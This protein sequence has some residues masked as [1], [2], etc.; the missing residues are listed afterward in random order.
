M[1]SWACSAAAGAVGCAN[2]T[3]I[4]ERAREAGSAGRN[5]G[6]G[7]AVRPAALGAAAA[8]SLRVAAAAAAAAAGCAVPY[9]PF[10]RDVAPV[11]WRRRCGAFPRL[12]PSLL[13]GLPLVLWA[14]F[15]KIQLICTCSNKKRK[16]S[17]QTKNCEYFLQRI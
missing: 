7:V 2:S 4:V 11:C 3:P 14:L 9:F 17:K 15:A 12:S 1:R 8:V 16:N 10:L 6:V 5:W 13:C